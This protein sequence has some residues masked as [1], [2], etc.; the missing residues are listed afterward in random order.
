V[1]AHAHWRA[2]VASQEIVDLVALGVH[3]P[4]I[5]DHQACEANKKQSYAALQASFV[6]PTSKHILRK[7]E[8]SH[9]AVHKMLSLLIDMWLHLEFQI[10]NGLLICSHSLLVFSFSFSFWFSGRQVDILH[11]VCLC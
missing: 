6:V 9:Q 8:Y 1:H 10:S 2:F 3:V 7:A 4:C 11:S 5:H